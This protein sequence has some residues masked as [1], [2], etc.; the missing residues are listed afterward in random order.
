MATRSAHS[1]RPRAAGHGSPPDDQPLPLAEAKLE[2]PRLR[3]EAV[4]RERILQALDSSAQTALTLVAAPLG[5][6][7]TTAV[8]AW[9]ASRS[10]AVVWVTLDDRDNDPVRLW[11]YVATAVNRQRDGLGR[12]ALRR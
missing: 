9:C 11:T 2:P 8:R 12:G 5:Y 1:S 4:R 6:G 3:H 10:P 7:K